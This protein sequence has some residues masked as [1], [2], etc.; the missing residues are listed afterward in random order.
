MRNRLQAFGLFGNVFDQNTQPGLVQN[1]LTGVAGQAQNFAQVQ[2]ARQAAEAQSGQNATSLAAQYGQSVQNAATEAQR[3]FEQSQALAQQDLQNRLQREQFQA[4]LAQQQAQY[5]VAK[6]DRGSSRPGRM[7]PRRT[8]NAQGQMLSET[9]TRGMRDLELALQ[10]DRQAALDT[11]TQYQA[12]NVPVP[13]EVK[14]VVTF[15]HGARR[16]NMFA[17]RQAD[18]GISRLHGSA[19][20][21]P[22]QFAADRRPVALTGAMG[23][24][25]SVRN[26]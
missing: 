11:L 4:N 15:H 25:S 5:G 7:Q 23:R 13:Q 14:D 24:L 2:A 21:S 22:S 16:A 17:P 9:P 26:R 12:W 8:Y 10:G 19:W 20:R 3:Q 18:Q 6:V 1:P